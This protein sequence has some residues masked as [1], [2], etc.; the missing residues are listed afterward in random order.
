MLNKTS[1]QRASLNDIACAE[2]EPHAN[3]D[4]GRFSVTGDVVH[5]RPQ[6]AVMIGMAFHELATNAV[7]M[8]RSPF[9][10]C[11]SSRARF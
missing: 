6:A 9:V 1:W 10:E 2:L 5:L 11:R 8:G 4:T 3:G 7:N